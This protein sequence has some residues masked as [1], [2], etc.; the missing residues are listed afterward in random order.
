MPITPFHFGPG[1]LIKAVAPKHV[2][3]TTFALANCLIDLEPILYFL[4][5]GEPAHRFLHT[6]PGATLAALIAIWPGKPGCEMMLRF[7]NRRLDVRQAKWL[8]TGAAIAN[9]P[10]VMGALLGA[11]THIALDA[12]MHAAMRPFWPL[13]ESNPWHGWLS[14]DGLHWLCMG[15]GLL[16]L[17][18]W[19]GIHS[20]RA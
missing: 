2:S 13:L 4:F 12:A 10:A 3:W 1:A 9:V 8:G 7:W 18:V 19:L 6:L 17:V 11:W 16:A 20:R 5:T 15:S 14:V